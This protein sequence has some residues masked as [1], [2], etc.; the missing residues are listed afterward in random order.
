LDAYLLA[1]GS[2]GPAVMAGIGPARAGNARPERAQTS[3]RS[4]RKRW[5]WTPEPIG[6]VRRCEPNRPTGVSRR[7]GPTPIG[8]WR[9]LMYGAPRT[10]SSAPPTR[11]LRLEPCAAQVARTVLGGG[12]PGDGP[13]LP[14]QEFASA[15][16]FCRSH[17]ELRN[18]LRPRTRR[19]QH[20][21]ADRRRLLHLRRATTVLAILEAA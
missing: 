16:R 4:R 10:G 2:E 9:R 14:D 6:D 21:P 5:D 18:F 7:S 17:D 1:G 20:V 15:E 19:S 13:P 12:R 8:P 3:G 11:W